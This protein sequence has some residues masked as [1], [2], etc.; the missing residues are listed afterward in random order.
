MERVCILMGLRSYSGVKDGMYKHVPAQ[1]LGAKVLR[2]LRKRCKLEDSQINLIIGGNA[3]G[4]GGNI[5]RLAAL[6]AGISETVAAVTVDLQ[7]GSALESITMAAAMIESKAAEVVVAGGFE[8]SSTQPIRMWNPNHPDY[9]ENKSYTVA[10]FMPG[11]QGEQ[12]MLEGAELTAFEEGVTKDEMDAWIL[13]SHKAASLT[14]AKGILSD[15]TVS[16][17]G[18]VKDEGIRAGM[19]QRLLDRLPFIL[20]KGKLMTAANACMMNDGAAF[21]VL[22]SDTYA[23]K[24]GMQPKAYFRKGVLVGGNPLKSPRTAVLAVEKLIQ[25]E[26]LDY[27]EIDAYEVNEAFALIDVLFHRKFPG[28]ENR[29]NIFGGALA[30]GH[31]YGASGAMILIHLLKALEINKG[32]YGICSV[33]AAGGIGSAI[34][35]EQGDR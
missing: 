27:R 33:A 7:C 32:R 3:V 28:V 5:T 19:S 29:Y 31:P 24:V 11:I 22:C 6:E 8:S 14:A 13:R 21:V 35:V 25:E 30:Y 12:V 9:V 1:E 20:P 16:V 26:E 4:G 18:S 34:L 10:K 17:N 2:E 23:R 15:V